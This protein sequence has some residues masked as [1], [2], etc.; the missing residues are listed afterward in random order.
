MDSILFIQSAGKQDE[1]ENILLIAVVYCIIY[2]W[3]KVNILSGS[4]LIIN[5][6]CFI[7]IDINELIVLL[8]IL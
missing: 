4:Y 1:I 6:A 3:F 8:T 2:F 5:L 7:R